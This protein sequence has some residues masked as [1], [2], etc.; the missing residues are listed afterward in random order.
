M[1]EAYPLS[2][3]AGWPRT[4]LGQRERGYQFKQGVNPSGYGKGFVTFAVARDK[5]YVELDRLGARQVIISTN[6]KP[7]VRGL[8]I[9]SKRKVE[10][11]GVAV[12]FQFK[13]RSMT[14]ACDRFDNA[15]A[16]MRS[17]GLAIDAL[18]QLERHGGGTMMD[19]A[20]EGFTALPPPTTSK[21]RWQDVFNFAPG[22][23]VSPEMLTRRYKELILTA[24]PDTAEGSHDKMTELNVAYGD[25]RQELAEARLLS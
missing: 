3:P 11:D 10:D 9:E 22:A 6:H 8:P 15:A 17:L 24:H 1:T 25:A 7:D 16:N 2:W 21:R 20:F 13:G 4:P 23:A 19:R 5:L 12:Y 18:R 14:M